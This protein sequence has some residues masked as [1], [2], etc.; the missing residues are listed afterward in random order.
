MLTKEILLTLLVCTGSVSAG[1]IEPVDTPFSVC[2]NKEEN[3]SCEVI[4]LVK[5][6]CQYLKDDTVS[7]VSASLHPLCH[8]DI[9]ADMTSSVRLSFS[10]G[11]IPST[12]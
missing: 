3:A 8:I 6:T 10:A 2:Q 1:L 7:L 5:G 11:P 12:T 4:N 9:R